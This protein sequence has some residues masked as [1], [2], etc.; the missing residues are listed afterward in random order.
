MRVLAV[1]TNKSKTATTFLQFYV[2]L[3]LFYKRKKQGRCLKKVFTL[4]RMCNYSASFITILYLHQVVSAQT[5]INWSDIF[6][7]ILCFHL[8]WLLKHII[9]GIFALTLI[10]YD[11]RHLDFR[12]SEVSPSLRLN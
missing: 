6:N 8:M 9:V 1:I 10:C 3:T 5:D 7:M 4:S 12:F 2:V 11:R